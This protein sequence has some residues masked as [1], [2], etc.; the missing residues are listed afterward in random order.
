MGR[1]R[2][3]EDVGRGEKGS[4]VVHQ[5]Q[6]FCL[7]KSWDGGAGCDLGMRERDGGW[8]SLYATLIL[9]SLMEAGSVECED[10]MREVWWC[11]EGE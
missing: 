9:T 5:L 3:S 1:Q 11:E 2:R 8:W 6:C 10:D 4:A 7:H